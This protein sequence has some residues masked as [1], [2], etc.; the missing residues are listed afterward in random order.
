M[1]YLV[2]YVVMAIN[3]FPKTTSIDKISP[4]EY[5]LGRKINYKTDLRITF[6]EYAQVSI[7]NIVSNDPRVPRTEGAIALLPTGNREG[8]IWFYLLGTG[9]IVR[10]QNFTT[11]PIPQEVIDRL[12][13]MDGRSLRRDVVITYGDED[14]MEESDDYSEEL[15]LLQEL[16]PPLHQPAL[17]D[18]HEIDIGIDEQ[19]DE[20]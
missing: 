1:P 11:L 18:Y 12:N 7:P 8:S 2:D 15:E 20:M 14:E 10:R 3:M 16:S 19:S 4:R 9:S 6:G 13:N 5:F 17:N